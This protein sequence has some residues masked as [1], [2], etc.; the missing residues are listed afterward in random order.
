MHYAFT[1]LYQCGE[2]KYSEKLYV[3]TRVCVCSGSRRH[4]K[5]LSSLLSY[6]N[7]SLSLSYLDSLIHIRDMY[8]RTVQDVVCPYIYTQQAATRND[9][10]NS[11]VEKERVVQAEVPAS[12]TTEHV[13]SPSPSSSSS[14]SR[15]QHESYMTN[16]SLQQHIY[17]TLKCD[18]YKR[19]ER[20][21]RVYREEGVREIDVIEIC[22]RQTFDFVREV[23]TVQTGTFSL[24]LTLPLCIS[25]SLS[26]SL[27]VCLN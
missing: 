16:F 13:V 18:T 27:S 25:L 1:S 17:L 24:Y 2:R 12:V 10:Q 3:F 19:E 5:F 7:L 15:S 22:E 8:G 20:S 21:M 6:A 23:L 9:A 11:E 26:L 4:W 14:S